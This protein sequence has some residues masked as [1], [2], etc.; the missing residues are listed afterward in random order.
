MADKEDLSALFDGQDRDAATIEVLEHDESMQD[1]W[2]SYSITRDVLRNDAPHLQWDIASKVALALEN[3]PA[4]NVS[5]SAEQT[6]IQMMDTKLAQ[7]TPA[8][9][10]QSKPSWLKMPAWFQQVS[11]VGIA[12]GVAMAVIVGVQ[13]Y[14]G[15]DSATSDTVNI[16]PPV[17]LTVPLKGTAEPV[18]LTTQEMLSVP[19]EAQL[20]EQRRRINAVL[21]D[22]ELQL[23]INAN[24]AVDQP[25]ALTNES[26]EN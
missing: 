19:T 15:F 6:V 21:N 13:Q 17:L 14:N 2:K 12:A 22:Y 7:P 26:I 25:A 23:R 1:I 3:E 5:S 18:S 11:Q 16:Q 20:M 8:Q 4:H 24:D 10:A 9:A